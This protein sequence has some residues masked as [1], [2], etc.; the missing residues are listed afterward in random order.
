MTKQSEIALLTRLLDESYERKAWQGP[1]LRGSLRGVSAAQAA[2]RPRPGRH[3]IWELVLHAAYWK[4]AAWRMLA[5][6]KRG[7]FPEK[8]SNW[9]VRPVSPTER[10]WRADLAL[11]DAEHRRLRAAVTGLSRA[12][13]SSKPRGSKYRTDTLVY[14]V[15]SHDVYHTGQIQALKRLWK[16]RRNSR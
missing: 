16:D 15:A 12:S 7:A 14:G 8:G 3:N 9:F 1:N 2:W 13:L 10:A 4:Y 11:L 6:E 5:G